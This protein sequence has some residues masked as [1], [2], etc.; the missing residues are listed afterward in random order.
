MINHL[1]SKKRGSLSCLFFCCM[2]RNKIANG[3]SPWPGCF[4]VIPRFLPQLLRRGPPRKFGTWLPT[5]ANSSGYAL[6]TLEKGSGPGADQV[7]NSGVH[8]AIFRCGGHT[9]RQVKTNVI[10]IAVSVYSDL[11]PSTAPTLNGPV[12]S[13]H[14]PATLA[15]KVPVTFRM[16]S[17]CWAPRAALFPPCPLRNKPRRSGVWLPTTANSSG[18]APWAPKRGSGLGVGRQHLV[19]SFAWP[20]IER[21]IRHKLH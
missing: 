2:G 4:R 5:T 18:Y 17:P 1:K 10:R 8:G 20:E 12:P 21:H 7:T 14:I 19:A 3:V 13:R 9:S 11:L 15:S 6:R 16:A